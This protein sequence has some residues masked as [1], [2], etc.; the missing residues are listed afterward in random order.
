MNKKNTITYVLG[1]LL[2]AFGVI[3]I[4]TPSTAFKS[5]ASAIAIVIILL[6][7]VSII[8]A[9]NEKNKTPYFLTTPILGI[10]FG[11][12]ILANKDSAIKI[13]PILLGIYLLV[14]SIST[15]LMIDNNKNKELMFKTIVKLILGIIFILTPIVP[16]VITGIIIGI[17]LVLTGIT[18]ITDVKDNEIVY[19]VKVKK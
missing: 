6:S 7:V 18:T 3:F 12:I 10:I 15:L 4:L 11:I 5:I 16:I 17:F 2:I 8:T 9:L 1:A 13:I 14:T 19:K